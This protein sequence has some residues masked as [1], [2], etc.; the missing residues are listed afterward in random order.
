MESHPSAGLTDPLKV[1]LL[2]KA[3]FNSL[4]KEDKG[5]LIA[6]PIPYACRPVR[7]TRAPR[8]PVR[9]FH[10]TLAKCQPPNKK[11]KSKH[12]ESS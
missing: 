8:D 12:I 4:P 10:S 2:L 1:S 9:L 3:V 11:S 7:S 6:R 5:N